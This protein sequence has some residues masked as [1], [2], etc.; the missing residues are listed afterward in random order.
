MNVIN[1]N[2]MCISQR[3][4][5]MRIE[6][7]SSVNMPLA[8]GITYWQL[9]IPSWVMWYLWTPNKK[10]LTQAYTY[11]DTV[12]NPMYIQAQYWNY[13]GKLCPF[14]LLIATSII[15]NVEC[16]CTTHKLT[17]YTTVE[18]IVCTIKHL[19]SISFCSIFTERLDCSTMCCSICLCL[20]YLDKKRL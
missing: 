13:K 20:Y 17:A 19:H 7:A 2:L 18:Y 9:C 8:W 11:S 1:E 6:C 5:P 3:S 15:R 12:Q 10:N 14:S 16:Y 4:I